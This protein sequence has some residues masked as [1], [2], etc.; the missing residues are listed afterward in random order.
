MKQQS[1]LWL[2]LCG[3]LFLSIH[4]NAAHSNTPESN[5]SESNTSQSNASD[6]SGSGRGKADGPPVKFVGGLAW[7]YTE[8][9]FNEKLDADTAFNT[10]TATGG[11]SRGKVY[12]SL[13]LS[14][15]VSSE[16]ISEEDELG[17]A[18]RTDIDL[19]F[20]YRAN[21]NWALFAGYRAGST[22]IDF[23][24]R[25]SDIEQEEFYR[26]DGFFAGVSY[27]LPMGRPGNLSFTFAYTHYDTDL[28][29]TAGFE[30]EDEAEE[31][32]EAE[33]ALEFDDLEGR[34]RGTSDGY[35]A[36]ISW[37]VPLG[38]SLAMRAQYKV[39]I[40]DLDVNVDGERFQPAQRLVYFNLGL[41][42]A[43]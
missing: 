20:G 40:Y 6:S 13:A 41:L 16:N 14:T 5:A 30:E 24:I 2:L 26:E 9:T 8:L 10:L 1:D 42:Y 4:S 3:W 32:E 35:S 43:F 7:G 36:G 38:R 34:Y 22:D 21:K 11:L 28:K 29:F 25:D 17:S 33:E 39:N 18:T 27:M 23:T 19:N 15:S 31:E 12:S 37:V